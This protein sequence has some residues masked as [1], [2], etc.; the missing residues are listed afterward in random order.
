M[1]SPGGLRPSQ[2]IT[3]FGPGSLVDYRDDTVM[4]MGLQ[5]WTD[6][7]IYYNKILEPRLSSRLNVSSFR[8]P[9]TIN[10]RGGVPCISFPKYRICSVCNSLKND[11]TRDNKGAYH[12]ECKGK[13]P[14]YPARLIVACEN[15]HIDDFPWAAWCHKKRGVCAS[16]DL[17][18]YTRG[19][20]SSLD[21][22]VVECKS[23]KAKENLGG[24]LKRDA[25]RNVVGT[26]SGYSPW[27]KKTQRNCR[28]IPRGIQR[29]AS[30]VY[31]SSTISALSIPPWSDE[32]QQL[33]SSKWADIKKSI[34]EY[35]LEDLRGGIRYIFPG[36]AKEEYERLFAAI[37]D[38]YEMEYKKE[39]I[40]LEEW[41]AFQEKYKK[42][43]N[44]HIEEEQVDSSISKFISRVV[45]VHRLRE[46]RA[47]RG[48]TRIDYPDPHDES[49][50][51]FSFL[52]GKPVDWLPAVE[53]LGEGI[54]I[55]LS[56]DV[57]KI[58]EESEAVVQRYKK[59]LEKYQDWRLEK[60][61]DEDEFFSIRFMLLH[62]LSHAL[63]RE[64]SLS[65]GYSSNSI[66]E[67]IYSG[68]SMCGILLY[69]ASP[70]S[71]GSLGGIIQQG[72]K[73]QFGKLIKQAVSRARI[74]SSDP[75]C[76]ETDEVAENRLNLSAC[77]A[78]SL[79]AETS[80]EWSNRLL[81]RLSLFKAEDNEVGFFE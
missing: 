14:T 77:H 55:Q 25:L 41:K 15:G 51:S 10:G 4:I 65:C 49:N 69:T 17:K 39:D 33:V 76:S 13:N 60:G 66:R 22:I 34:E 48:F 50:V 73:E 11:F 12:C 53:V 56:Q 44:F 29:G 21:D 59:M 64:L 19:Q 78:C 71:D 52:S 24:A 57:L 36:K 45:L 3:T 54:F 68:P 16:A 28:S 47:L 38:Q 35:G 80:C 20:S 43:K 63:I 61:W 46:V 23:C 79:I 67:K 32:T 75:L 9:R 18:I 2:L 6:D 81:D 5:D 1:K 8:Q 40:R 31:F 72:R 7:P 62:S 30:N 70:D 27:I 74:C 37:K 58:W 42:T 26:C